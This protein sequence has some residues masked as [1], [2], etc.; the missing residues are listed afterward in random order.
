MVATFDTSYHNKFRR[1]TYDSVEDLED[2]QRTREYMEIFEQKKPPV[3]TPEDEAEY[4]DW[5]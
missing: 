2:R 5:L 1:P 4:I 3:P